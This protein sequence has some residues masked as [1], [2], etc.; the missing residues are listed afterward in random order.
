MVVRVF[1]MYYVWCFRECILFLSLITVGRLLTHTRR[2]NITV[3]TFSMNG[4]RVMV[5]TIGTTRRLRTPVVLRVTRM[6]LGD[7]PLRLVKPVVVST[8]RGTGISVTIRLSRKLGIGAIRRT[9]SV[10]FASMVLSNSLLPL[11]GGVGAMG[12][13]IRATG[14]CNTAIRTRLK[15]INKGRNRNGDRGVLYAGPSSTGHFY[16]RAKISTLTIT[17]NG[18][19][20]GCPMLPRLHFSILRRVRGGIGAPLILRNNANVDSRR[21]RETVSLNIH[22]VGVT[23]TS[24][25]DLT[26]CTGA[27]YSGGR[28]TGCFRLSTYRI[29]NICR[30]IGERVGIFGVRWLE[31]RL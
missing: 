9:L 23:A 1:L 24:F 28:G 3:N 22:G 15:I 7:S 5:N 12:N 27:C 2:G 25:S 20:K 29:R 10:N 16:S 19:R 30:G 21:F 4:V 14:R 6:E 31:E 8:T 17:V 11:R 26:S 13:I 18:T